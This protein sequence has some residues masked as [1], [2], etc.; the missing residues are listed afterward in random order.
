[1]ASAQTLQTQDKAFEGTM[2]FHGLAGVFGAGGRETARRGQVR[3]K[4]QLIAPD[5]EKE[6]L[7]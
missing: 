3:R 4:D 6:R 7:L 2:T 1:M 5:D